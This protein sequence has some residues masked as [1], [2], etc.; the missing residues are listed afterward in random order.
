[1]KRRVLALGLDP[2]AVDLGDAR[3]TPEKVRAYIDAEMA[4]IAALGV[5]V[6]TC[7]V[8]PGQSPANAVLEAL[9]TGAFDVVMLGA[10]L[11]SPGQQLLFE[12]VLNLVHAHAP[13][14]RLCFNSR[15]GDS[16]EAVQRW[17]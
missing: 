17:L 7:L 1:M 6:V 16:A 12:Q 13:Q 2:V 3:F 10:G 14:A 4:R 11:N 5:E 8:H 9:H 15:P